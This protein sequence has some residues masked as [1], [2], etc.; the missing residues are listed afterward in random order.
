MWNY[1]EGKVKEEGGGPNS[2]GGGKPVTTED[3]FVKTSVMGKE[4][5]RKPFGVDQAFDQTAWIYSKQFPIKYC[6][7]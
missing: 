2:V 4:V 7:I 5:I 3:K 6:K 1:K